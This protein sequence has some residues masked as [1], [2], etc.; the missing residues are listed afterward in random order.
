MH[1]AT[2]DPAAF[3]LALEPFVFNTFEVSH[4]LC[5]GGKVSRI[6]VPFQKTGQDTLQ[7]WFLIKMRGPPPPQTILGD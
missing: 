2:L 3:A 5:S 6:G 4:D 1:F 7:C